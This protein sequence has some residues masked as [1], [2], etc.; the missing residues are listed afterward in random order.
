MKVDVL[1]LGEGPPPPECDPSPPPSLFC[2]PF[3]TLRLWQ[4]IRALVAAGLQVAVISEVPGGSAPPTSY[5]LGDARVSW[6]SVLPG[7]LSPA[8]VSA[9]VIR[10][11]PRCVVSLGPFS[12]ARAAAYVPAGVPVWIDLPGDMMAEA[13][14]RA[15]D[16]ISHLTNY[17]QILT[18]AL[19]RGDA[20]SVCS[21]PQQH[22]L[23]GQLGLMGRLSPGDLQGPPVLVMPPAV[24]PHWFGEAHE[25]GP[26]LPPGTP[27]VGLFGSINTWADVPRLNA[28]LQ[29][30]LTRQPTLH[31]VITGGVV[32]SHEEGATSQL[33]AGLTAF[34]DRI[35]PQGWVEPAR[36][37][38]AVDSC[39]VAL[40]VDKP[41]V[42]AYLGAR[43]RLGLGV[44][45]GLR[46]VLTPFVY[47]AAELGRQG[48]AN[49]LDTPERDVDTLLTAMAQGKI[50]ETRRLA[51]LESYSTPRVSQ[52]LVTW[53]QAPRLSSPGFP[54]LVHRDTRR[55]LELEETLDTIY[56]S[57]TWRRL[58]TLHRW[59]KGKVPPGGS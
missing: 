30:A 51:W 43:T 48:L 14:L 36:L 56:Q 59:L 8:V 11:S 27:A 57:P 4:G 52:S 9:E 17:H 7:Q 31:V 35:H 21:P 50:D 39:Q 25:A 28:L 3:P 41:C 53:A 26:L 1:I 16:D 10:F 22:A 29:G 44:A 20:F 42:E 24:D 23:W 32:A 34:G 5:R 54:D 33:M 55:R 58:S 47:G 38:S 13:Q 37:L 12:P 19:V 49:P 6:W 15:K 45:R 46:W 40:L 18:A 2:T